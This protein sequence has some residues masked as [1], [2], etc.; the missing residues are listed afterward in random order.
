MTTGPK[1]RPVADRFWKKVPDQPGMDCWEWTGA[2]SPRG[3]GKFL[4]GY[5]ADKT[6][7]MSMA[8]R[9]AYELCCGEPGNLFVCHAC[10][11]PSCVNPS[12]LFLGTH[13]DNMKDIASKGRHSRYNALKT[14][15]KQGHEFTPENT[16]IS[17][18]HR[19]CRKCTR[20]AGRRSYYRHQAKNIAR[21]SQYLKLKRE[22]R[23]ASD[24]Y[25]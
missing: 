18:G 20:A 12:H 23:R 15:C 13:T 6:A 3:Y 2:R 8:H 9:V 19:Q 22:L 4:T 24:E 7:Q 14:H 25:R 21:V 10:D 16:R 17:N 11:N 5:R 1:A